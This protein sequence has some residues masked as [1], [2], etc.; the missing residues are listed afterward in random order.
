MKIAYGT[1]EGSFKNGLMHGEG[2]FTWKDGRIYKG[3]FKDGKM[4]GQG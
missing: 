3:T 4:H 2:K 1:Y